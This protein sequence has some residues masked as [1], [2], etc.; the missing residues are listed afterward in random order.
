MVDLEC[1]LP[2]IEREECAVTN[3]KFCEFLTIFEQYFGYV[4]RVESMRENEGLL[5]WGMA[6]VK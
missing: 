2:I 5:V 1:R 6:L 3:L 4:E